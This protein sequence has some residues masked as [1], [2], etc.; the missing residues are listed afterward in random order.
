MDS[1]SPDPSGFDMVDREARK[2]PHSTPEVL[3]SEIDRPISVRDYFKRPEG[4]HDLPNEVRAQIYQRGLAIIG[5]LFMLAV[6]TFLLSTLMYYGTSWKLTLNR[7]EV[8]IVQSDPGLPIGPNG[9]IF[10]VGQALADAFLGARNPADKMPIGRFTVIQSPGVERAEYLRKETHDEEIWAGI[11]IPANLTLDYFL[12]MTGARDYFN[13][14][15][16]GFLN[17]GRQSP[18]TTTVRGALQAVVNGFNTQFA[19]TAAAGGLGPLDLNL[20]VP[21]ALVQPVS[22]HWTV[23]FQTIAGVNYFIGTALVLGWSSLIPVSIGVFNNT[24]EFYKTMSPFRV[25]MIRFAAFVLFCILLSLTWTII[26][27]AFGVPFATNFGAVWWW[28]FLVLLTFSALIFFFV[29]SLGPLGTVLLTPFMVL[30]ITTSNAFFH[31]ST[32]FSDF[33]SWGEAFPWYYAYLGLR[34][35]IFGTPNAQSKFPNAV[36]ILVAW[37]FIA[38]LLDWLLYI[39]RTAQRLQHLQTPDTA[40][41]KLLIGFSIGPSTQVGNAFGAVAPRGGN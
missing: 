9:T 30:M 41:G 34:R 28:F 37:W 21:Q 40:L 39:L 10:S 38:F 6:F 18:T 20:A 35:V 5:V 24:Q 26:L 32:Y 11:Q 8:T 36:G 13:T 33:Y 3:F 22:I 7:L 2:S 16:T 23:L 19:V 29:S 27:E 17:D 31:T 1:G 14:T 15:L 12:A 4:A 25:A